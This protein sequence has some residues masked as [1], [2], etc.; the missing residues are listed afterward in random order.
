MVTFWV[1]FAA[2]GELACPTWALGQERAI[3]F[4]YTNVTDVDLEMTVNDQRQVIKETRRYGGLVRIEKEGDATRFSVA[5]EVRSMTQ[6]GQRV[7]AAALPGIPGESLAAVLS[8]NGVLTRDGSTPDTIDFWDVLLRLPSTPSPSGVVT[9][10]TLSIRI[11]GGKLEGHIEYAVTHGKGVDGPSY[12]A[13][14][15]LNVLP[16]KTSMLPAPLVSI[17]TKTDCVFDSATGLLAAL[18]SR[19]TMKTETDPQSDSPVKTSATQVT[20][21]TLSRGA[22]E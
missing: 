10:N 5:A 12:Q 3:P 16:D 21:I 18:S 9:T 11:P 22:S 7:P 19:V 17:S 15:Q 13:K 8:K 6:N 1:P 2:R 14:G 4:S 20:A